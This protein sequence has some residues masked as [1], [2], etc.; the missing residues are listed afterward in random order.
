M[1]YTL[2]YFICLDVYILLIFVI[3]CLSEFIIKCKSPVNTN[4][5]SKL[6]INHNK[7]SSQYSAG[8]KK[9]F[10]SNSRPRR[11]LLKCRKATVAKWDWETCPEFRDIFL[12]WNRVAFETFHCYPNI[13]TPTLMH[14]TLWKTKTC[15]YLVLGI[16][17]FLP[18]S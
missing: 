14:F 18:R 1:I 13:H 6:V 7:I 12:A 2:I 8:R 16:L 11:P 4:S 10:L 17:V 3:F 9:T 15:F 5:E